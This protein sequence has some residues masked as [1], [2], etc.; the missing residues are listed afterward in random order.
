MGESDVKFSAQGKSM[1]NAM[2]RYA[3][4]RPHSAR[5]AGFTLIEILIVVVILGI[6]AAIAIPQFSSASG[7]ARLS[8][9]RDCLRFMRSQI[10]V[11]KAQHRDT[12]PGY[13]NGDINAAPDAAT[14]ISQMTGFTDETGNVSASPSAVFHYGPYL[15]QM[16][17]N[18]YNNQ[19]AL[20]LV[21]G[22]SMPAPDNQPYGWIYNPQT[23]QF[24]VNEPG[25]DNSGIP[26]ASY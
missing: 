21:T 9:M 11:Y 18:P 23:L 6:L 22:A 12:P 4:N 15:S 10:M 1:G 8:T 26:Y 5:G 14:F 25:N 7:E 17:S 16:P 19:F 2:K 13:P 3:N 24:I 20:R